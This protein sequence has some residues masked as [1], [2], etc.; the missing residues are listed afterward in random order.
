MDEVKR[1]FE[2]QRFSTNWIDGVQKVVLNPQRNS[3][4]AA[5]KLAMQFGA[6]K[7]VLLGYDCQHTGG[8]KHWHGDHPKGLGNAGSVQHWSMR[9]AGFARKVSG[10]EIVNA[11][12][13][14][15]L[16]CFPRMDLEDALAWI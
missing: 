16:E 1:T 10:V 11:S 8:K 7:I 4:L 2:G 6:E 9:F 14:T 3:G 15:A 13:K 5:I 12:R